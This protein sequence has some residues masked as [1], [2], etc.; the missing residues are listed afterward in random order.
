MLSVRWFTN[1]HEHRNYW[2]RFGFMRLHRAGRVRYREYP[3]KACMEAGFPAA[4]AAHEHRHTSVIAI[5]DGARTVRCIVDG[6]D[7]FFQLTSLIKHAD[8]Y[9]CA[10]Y[11][12]AFFEE[13]RF[14]PPY[15][16]LHPHE[17][18]HYA[19]KAAELVRSFSDCFSCVRP[20]VPIGPN[21]GGKLPTFPLSQKLINAH[22]KLRTRLHDTQPWLLAYLEFETRYR[23]L[24]ALRDASLSYDVVL[25]DTLWGWPRHRYALHKRLQS[26]AG[27]YSIH[28]RLKWHPP[29][30][31]DG[32]DREPLDPADFPI[33]TGYVGDYEQMLASSRLA[34]FATGFHWGW[35]NIMTLALMWG[36]PV[37]MDRLLLQP[38]FDMGRFEITWNEGAQW[39]G[40][41][42]T[43]AAIRPEVWQRIKCHNQAVF[44]EV[45]SPERVAEYVVRTALDNGRSEHK[46]FLGNS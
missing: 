28:S 21:M 15:A 33:E 40:L 32:S 12:A 20:F 38:W 11:N 22:H 46:M 37:Y 1:A 30:S 18:S 6:E 9:F 25:L 31:L 45:L 39:E 19:E 27:T 14:D 44:D 4:V 35:R 8:L 24:L 13:E 16:W 7:S 34:V 42:A 41:D 10:G 17:Y 23:R 36:L 2:L 3:L 29:C 43:L 26:L 5:D